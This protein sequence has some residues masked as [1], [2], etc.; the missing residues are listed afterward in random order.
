MSAAQ[1]IYYE[2]RIMNSE[3]CSKYI[4]VPHNQGVACT[5]CQN[6]NADIKE[7]NVKRHYTSKHSSLFEEILGQA[8]VD[9][10]KHL[11]KSIKKQQGVFTSYKKDSQLV[12]KLSFKL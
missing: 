4:V 5:V 3:W 7:Y 6:E 9:K 8:R 12:T 11:K 10:I 1:K 2:G